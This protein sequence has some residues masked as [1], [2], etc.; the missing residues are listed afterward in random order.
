MPD[1]IEAFERGFGKADLLFKRR[2][3][4][5]HLTKEAR[6]L[7]MD[8]FYHYLRYRILLQQASRSIGMDILTL[9]VM[10]YEDSVDDVYRSWWQSLEK[11]EQQRLLL[12]VDDWGFR[13]I[14]AVYS[15]R[16]DALI[17]YVQGR[18]PTTLLVL[19]RRNASDVVREHLIE[20]GVQVDPLL[21]SSALW[22]RGRIR[23]EADIFFDVQDHSSQ[24]MALFVS[25]QTS[26]IL[27]YCAGYGGKGIAMATIWPH[28][29]LTASDIRQ[30]LKAT[31]VERAKR[32]GIKF[33]WKSQKELAKSLY[34]LVVV[35][36][37]CSGS[38][39]WRRNPEDRYRFGQSQVK[40]LSDKQLDILLQAGKLVESGGELLYITCSLYPIENED[41]IERFL[42]KT[43][44]FSIVP[45]ERRLRE[46]CQILGI[47]HE[48]IEHLLIP[49]SYPYLRIAPQVNGGDLFFACL[50][51]KS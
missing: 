26:K 51:K 24:L 39:V 5:Y 22:V 12:S 36:A 30:E 11:R 3:R 6:F 37:P 29:E 18:A 46:N 31:V 28:I 9:I 19:L 38:G 40:T 44:Q 8:Y 7:V 4:R 50:L 33:R 13:Q 49:E 20:R 34:P 21:M 27:D 42:A 10:H 17:D 35:D 2:I 45:A 25:Q 41:V 47:N 48:A 16:L 1:L 43:S 14:E 23:D 32:A 15:E